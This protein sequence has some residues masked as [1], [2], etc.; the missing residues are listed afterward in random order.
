[1]T[2]A[3]FDFTNLIINL[4]APTGGFL[5]MDIQTDIYSDWKVA[6]KAGT[7]FAP[8]AFDTTAGDSL[9]TGVL[10]GVYFL[11][12]DLGWR[13]RSTD[14]DQE[15][16]INGNLY[17]RDSSITKYIYRTGRT[18]SY[19]LNLTANPRQIT[20]QSDVDAIIVAM[21]ARVMEGS[22]TFAEAMKLIRAEAAGTIVKVG[23][24]HTVRDAAD[25]KDR[26][27]ATADEDGRDVTAVDG[28]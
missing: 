11:R 27:T 15:I 8:P 16:T 7:N 12:N 26:I 21:F 3:T 4:P 5:T 9:P 10:T 13:I 22:E 14:E 18:V 17:P 25:T 19:E 24:V 1:M 2:A 20:S 23:D 28:S 6:L